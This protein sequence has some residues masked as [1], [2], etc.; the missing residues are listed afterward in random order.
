MFS[1]TLHASSRLSLRFGAVR[2]QFLKDENG[3]NVDNQAASLDSRSLRLRLQVTE[4]DA[5]AWESDGLS[6]Y[7]SSGSSDIVMVSDMGGLRG[8][9]DVLKD[10]P[11]AMAYF[12]KMFQV[13]KQ[14]PGQ[15]K[16]DGMVDA[17]THTAAFSLLGQEIKSKL[18]QSLKTAAE[19]HGFIEPLNQALAEN[20]PLE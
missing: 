5:A 19:K 11:S 12:Q 15:E 14:L 8:L 2:L 20:N 4:G 10:R 7:E 13:L 9:K 16:F 17:G 3:G 6:F 1:P 18:V